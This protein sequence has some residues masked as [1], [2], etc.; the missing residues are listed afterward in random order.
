MKYADISASHLTFVAEE[1]PARPSRAWAVARSPAFAF[2]LL[3]LFGIPI[4][5][6]HPPLR[7]PDEDKH[8]VR[9]YGIAQGEIVPSTVDRLGRKGIFIPADLADDFTFFNTARQK[10]GHEGFNYRQAKAEFE[11]RQVALAPH[12]SPREP[13]FIHYEGSEGY[14]PVGY[15]PYVAAALVARTGHL[16]FTSTIVLMRIFGFITMTALATYAIAMV[17]QV[18]W[19]FLLI[20]MLPAALYARAVISLD[21]SILGL[22]MLVSALCLK[23]VQDPKRATTWERAIWMALCILG[24]PPQIAFALFEAAVR[25]FRE[26]RQ[27]WRAAALVVVP[28]LLL[29]L[30]WILVVSGDVALW[31]LTAATGLSPDQFDPVRKLWFM[32]GHPLHFPNAILDSLRDG[33]N[34]WRQLI[35][36]LGWL[37]IPLRSFVYPT[38]SVMLMA[39]WLRPLTFD[40]DSRLRIAA[41]SGLTVITYCVA[42]FLAFY[43]T[44]TPLTHADIWG[45]QGRYFIVTLPLIAI[46]CAALLGGRIPRIPV[47]MIAIAGAI[48]SG[49][50]CIEA[51]ARAN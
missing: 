10:I 29:S 19:A 15:V 50:A 38:L 45:V 28:G 43:L 41:I 27:H 44:Y 39:T 36:V 18:G 42:V 23:A 35:G 30:L 9:A 7:G 22:T 34:L 4:I 5:F 16:S 17:P 40:R 20:A 11:R 13:V 37:D 21:G 24:K 2:A 49:V 51:I 48:F 26:L 31:R 47:A 14:T 8:F 46:A 1:K 3:S 25:P 32:L 33:A 6:L 12:E